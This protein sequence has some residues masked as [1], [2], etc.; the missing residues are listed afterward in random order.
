MLL[1]STC[2]NIRL[3]SS[4]GGVAGVGISNDG[5]FLEVDNLE[6]SGVEMISGVAGANTAIT[7]LSNFA[8]TDSSLQVRLFG[9]RRLNLAP[10]AMTHPCTRW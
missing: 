6:M 10:N 1:R 3:Y 8:V 4:Q 9:Y 5:G 7:S 2:F